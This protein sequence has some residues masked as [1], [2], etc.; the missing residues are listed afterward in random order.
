M[1][2]VIKAVSELIS[3]HWLKFLT[4]AG[5]T[6]VGWLIARQRAAREWKQRGFFHL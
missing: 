3:D 4:A 6:A 2:Q 5:F 1:D